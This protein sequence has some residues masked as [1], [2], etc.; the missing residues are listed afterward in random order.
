MIAVASS[1][2]IDMYR[3]VDNAGTRKL[4]EA[5]RSDDLVL[6]DV[7]LLEVLQGA[8]DDL[9]S[10]RIEIELRALRQERAMSP[11]LAI[12]GAQYSRKLKG[13]GIT[14]RKTIDLII[15][16]WCIENDCPLIHNDRDFLPMVRHLGLREY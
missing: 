4:K 11:N 7:V 2:F 10:Y 13:L 12:A 9:H 6:L 15:G 8:R 5:S 1:V 3:K 16:T 14:I